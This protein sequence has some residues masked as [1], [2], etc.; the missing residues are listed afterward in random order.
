M[1]EFAQGK[2]SALG[3]FKD[4]KVKT[5][6]L[7]AVLVMG[8][9]ERVL[10]ARREETN[11]VMGG[12]AAFPGG[13][14]HDVDYQANVEF[15]P[16]SLEGKAHL[17]SAAVREFF[18]ETGICLA[19]VTEGTDLATARTQLISG[20]MT[21]WDKIRI[22]ASK[23]CYYGYRTTPHFASRRFETHFL[24][25]PWVENQRS[26]LLPG[27]LAEIWEAPADVMLE[28]F[29]R[30]QWVMVPPV[31]E[32]LKNFCL[33][34][35]D[36]CRMEDLASIIPG[37]HMIPLKTNT[38]FP[39]THTNTLIVGEDPAW[40]VDPGAADPKE[41]ERFLDILKYAEKSLNVKF[42][43]IL[44]S[45]S[46][47]DHWEGI[48]DLKKHYPHLPVYAH[49]VVAKKIGIEA[50][51]APE[52]LKSKIN[53]RKD[54]FEFQVMVMEGHDDGHYVLFETTRKI[55]CSFDLVTSL[56]TVVLTGDGDVVTKYLQSLTMCMELGARLVIPSHGPPMVGVDAFRKT[57]AHRMAR[58]KQILLAL[59][60]KE[61]TVDELITEIYPELKPD[62]RWLGKAN[63]EAHAR[64]LIVLGKISQDGDKITLIKR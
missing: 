12:Y 1:C 48:H 11:P 47:R 8:N 20:N 34:D 58:E 26:V 49:P 37:I 24:G 30:A 6:T 5:P 29:Y 16:S 38:L 33:P 31:Q 43:G 54:F 27:E 44:I 25:H 36:Q 14:V 41:Q 15:L 7:S 57:F 3:Y 40:I 45:H 59:E 56:G 21:F 42:A 51:S 63:I 23:F 28:K 52:I 46:H 2:T 32:I 19:D 17:V 60:A 64:R 4:V 50:I 22:D 53:G 35:F 39:A 62:W 18:E 10:V 55:L 9:R 61:K 13:K